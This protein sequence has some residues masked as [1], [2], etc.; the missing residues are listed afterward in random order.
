MAARP[1]WSCPGFDI[2]SWLPFDFNEK[3]GSGWCCAQRF[4]AIYR[5]SS[6]SVMA[7]NNVHVLSAWCHMQSSVPVPITGAVLA[8]PVHR[9]GWISDPGMVISLTFKIGVLN[10]AIYRSLDKSSD[11]NLE[12]RPV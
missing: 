11:V 4:A 9:A 1:P 2:A 5:G 12:M 8:A 3:R 10:L 6:P 7:R